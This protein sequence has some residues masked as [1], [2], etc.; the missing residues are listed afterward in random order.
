VVSKEEV[1]ACRKAAQTKEEPSLE[2]GV[3]RGLTGPLRAPTK[4]DKS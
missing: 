1:A 4:V 3:S 2:F